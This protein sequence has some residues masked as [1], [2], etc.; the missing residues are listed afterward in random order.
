MHNG[1]VRVEII[2][3]TIAAAILFCALMIR[4]IIGVADNGDFSRV[5]A[6][7]GLDYTES[8]SQDRYF[9]YATREYAVKALTAIGGG[10]L[11][12]QVIP[13]K[14]A[15]LI[16]AAV[17][18]GRTFDIR[19]L[20]FIYS[21]VF[22]FSIYLVIKCNKRRENIIN[23]LMAAI[24]LFVFADLAY[25]SYFNSFYGEALSFVSVILTVAA[26]AWLFK[27]EKPG[28]I[29]LVLLF[30]AL[31][32]FRLYMAKKDRAWRII[33]ATSSIVLLVLSIAVFLCVPEGIRECNKYQS[34]FYGILKDSPAPAQDLEELGVDPAFAILAGTDY[35]AGN[36]PVDLG[37][38]AFREGFFD[39]VSH[40]KII[41][42]Y[43]KHP[44][45][46][47]QK[48]EKT[49][50]NGFLIKHGYGNYE[51]NPGVK[52]GE[53]VKSFTFWSDNKGKL[54]PNTLEFVLLFFAGYFLVLLI[55]R[56]ESKSLHE[57]I[58]LEVYILI[59]L[60]GAIQFMITVIGDGEA[61]LGRHLFLFGVCF[62]IM[63][64]SGVVWLVNTALGTFLN[65]YELL[66]Q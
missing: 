35:F 43:L 6:V 45:R 7:T 18:W 64:V 50:K 14:A 60:I 19:F 3:V 63:F 32:G 17:L 58:Y 13:V 52:Y 66:S 2:A 55:K 11:T 65:R 40:M 26:A 30:A 20:S 22:L 34:V 37:S 25:I 28:V 36:H 51:K 46:Y 59:G 44:V 56:F 9:G 61:D 49:A 39:R 27:S 21:I 53:A 42:F 4:P 23:W 12:T 62:D 38:Q 29:P 15:M 33:A 1:R 47:F 5:M 54:F 24:I 48:L 41:G 57:K 31:F 10:Y 8:S 16:Q